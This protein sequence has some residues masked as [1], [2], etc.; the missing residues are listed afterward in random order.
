MPTYV[1]RLEPGQPQRLALAYDLSGTRAIVYFDWQAV[2][3]LEGRTQFEQ[4]AE[5]QV[6]PDTTIRVKC[7]KTAFSPVPSVTWRGVELPGSRFIPPQIGQQ[8][9]FLLLFMAT[10]H[11][12]GGSFLVHFGFGAISRTGSLRRCFCWQQYRVRAIFRMERIP[13]QARV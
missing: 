13:R 7:T 5:V 6:A 11:N 10:I 12:S 2:F 9:F 3:A 4:G 8:T 1:Y